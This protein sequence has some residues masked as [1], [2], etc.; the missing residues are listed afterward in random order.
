MFDEAVDLHCH[1]SG[2]IWDGRSGT[3]SQIFLNSETVPGSSLGD[4]PRIF[5]QFIRFRLKK[6]VEK[7][8]V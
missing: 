6:P 3:V 2:E 7:A 5:P 8:F 1:H 4:C